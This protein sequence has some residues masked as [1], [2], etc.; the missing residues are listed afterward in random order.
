MPWYYQ[1]SGKAEEH[2][3]AEV[4]VRA[5]VGIEPLESRW[6]A[7]RDAVE[8]RERGI[9]E[10]LEQP[11]EAWAA[12]W[13]VAAGC[14]SVWRVW[15]CL[16]DGGAPGV[17]AATRSRRWQSGGR[18]TRRRG[19][20]L[21]RLLPASLSRLRGTSAGAQVEALAAA[22]TICRA[23]RCRRARDAEASPRRE[24]YDGV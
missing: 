4:R 23:T 2:S 17:H 24:D 22:R 19:R 7:V 18:A 5:A 6:R 16:L 1:G 21:L 9:G 13:G 3:W 11:H 15:G 20:L 12:G 10:P 14:A 8:S